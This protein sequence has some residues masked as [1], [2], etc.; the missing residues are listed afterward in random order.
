MLNKKGAMFGLDARIALAIFG[1]LSV[2]SGAAL[3][4]AIQNARMESYR[5]YFNGHIKASEQY[6]LD[7]GKP[8]PQFS[9]YVLYTPDLII[10]RESLKTWKGPYIDYNSSSISVIMDSVSNQIGT[11]SVFQLWL[12]PKSTWASTTA[13]N[14]CVLGSSDCT[15]Y[16]ALYGGT[17]EGE[18]KIL[19]IFNKLDGLIDS[20]DGA[21][22][23]KV[24]FNSTS[25]GYLMYQGLPRVRAS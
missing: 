5:Q 7:N 14:A 8:I 3:Y 22:D 12:A 15:E 24:R 17:V 16:M 4:S 20:S 23:G 19:D 10:N 1:A 21:A 13:N 18:A 2:I 11:D 25:F 6:Y 9:S